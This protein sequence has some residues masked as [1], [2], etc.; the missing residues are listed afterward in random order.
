MTDIPPDP[1]AEPP[2]DFDEEY[3][4][5]IERLNDS[6]EATGWKKGDPVMDYSEIDTSSVVSGFQFV[7]LMTKSVTGCEQTEHDAVVVEYEGKDGMGVKVKPKF[8]QWTPESEKQQALQ[9]LILKWRESGKLSINLGVDKGLRFPLAD[10]VKLLLD[11]PGWHVSDTPDAARGVPQGLVDG[12]SRTRDNETSS[13]GQ[14]QPP[15]TPES[16]E[17]DA[18]LKEED[19]T[20][21]EPA[22]V[23]D[24][25]DTDN[26]EQNANVFELVSQNFLIVF[27][28]K[29]ATVSNTKGARIAKCLI[30]NQG[31]NV[32]IER[33][34]GLGRKLD[35]PSEE[36]SQKS[37]DELSKQGIHRVSRPNDKGEGNVDEIMDPEYTRQL[38]ERLE[39][40][41][42]E[43]KLAEEQGN[44]EK[45]SVLDKEAKA[46][47]K[48]FYKGEPNKVRTS[49]PE[50]RN[51]VSTNYK[52]FMGPW[53]IN[54]LN[55]MHI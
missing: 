16:A 39:K 5:Y 52:K 48:N 18:K 2:G 46:I 22:L 21:P 55:F 35:P 49:H 10:A 26:R 15:P 28:G 45:I 14:E 40:I 30:E 54:F 53:K 4:K 9:F 13:D 33:L 11:E 47:G 6:I 20:L 24:A 27:N 42:S 37:N 36:F 51:R 25:N 32:D 44:L 38:R 8:E 29:R 23:V 12:V 1:C 31:E 34:D 19:V 50:A 41:R 7:S 3:R 43:R 17:N